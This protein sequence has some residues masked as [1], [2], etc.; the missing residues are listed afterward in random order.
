MG[1]HS[2]MQ[3]AEGADLKK[4]YGDAVDEAR[5]MDGA[6][7]YNGT[8]STTNGVVAVQRNPVPQAKASEYAASYFDGERYQNYGIQKWE[9]AGAIPVAADTAFKQRQRT[10]TVTTEKPGH[11]AAGEMRKMAEK[12]LDLEPGEE[13]TTVTIEKD[14]ARRRARS[15]RPEGKL[16]TRYRVEGDFRYHHARYATAGE[17]RR[18][19]QAELKAVMDQEKETGRPQFGQPQ[20]LSYPVYGEVVRVADDGK[21]LPLD[22]VSG[23]ISQRKMKLRVTILRQTNPNPPTSGWLLFGWAAS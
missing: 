14:E 10:V 6:D 8:I 16:V 22:L 23:L 19:A 18:A 20:T 4:V 1:A 15:K 3:Y 7:P 11:L 5:H 21:A 2:F 9:Y 12:A 17:A 13:V